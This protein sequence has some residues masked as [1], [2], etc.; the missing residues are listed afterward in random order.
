MEDLC[1]GNRSCWQ[2]RWH[3]H[4]H[5][6]RAYPW[7]TTSKRAQS[8]AGDASISTWILQRHAEKACLIHFIILRNSQIY[9]IAWNH[10]RLTND[11]HGSICQK[12][13]V[14]RYNEDAWKINIIIIKHNSKAYLRFVIKSRWF[15][16]AVWCMRCSSRV[17]YIVSNWRTQFLWRQWQPLR[18]QTKFASQTR[19]LKSLPKLVLIY[20]PRGCEQQ[21]WLEQVN[22]HDLLEIV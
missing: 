6:G 7:I 14:R 11:Y 2:H 18:G 8:N 15:P 13:C 3:H 22:L 19:A 20:Q 9:A 4:H 16:T 21:I 12:T 17:F 10:K 5:S 1:S